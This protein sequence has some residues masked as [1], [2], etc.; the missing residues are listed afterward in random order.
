MYVLTI[1]VHSDFAQIWVVK[2]MRSHVLPLW[3]CLRGSG[4]ANTGWDNSEM[5]QMMI[6][7]SVFTSYPPPHYARSLHEAGFYALPLWPLYSTHRASPEVNYSQNI[8]Y[9]E[10]PIILVQ[11]SG[12][13]YKL[14]WMTGEQR[15]VQSFD[16]S[17]LWT[18]SQ[19]G[20]QKSFT[21]LG[22]GWQ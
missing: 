7:L 8:L 10:I 17:H 2:L 11:L 5:T 4:L 16:P 18:F 12:A 15:K 1:C 22:L 21:T 14:S 3:L 6:E 20:S 13:F 9:N 19:I